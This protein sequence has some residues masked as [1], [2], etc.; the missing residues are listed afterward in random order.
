MQHSA[1]LH[2]ISIKYTVNVKPL[3]VLMSGITLFANAYKSLISWP[4][5]M[6]PAHHMNLEDLL[7][8]PKEKSI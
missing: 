6:M 4:Y 3:S 5:H 7:R 1:L 8:C 2:D